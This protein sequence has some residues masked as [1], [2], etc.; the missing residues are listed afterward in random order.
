MLVTPEAIQA[1]RDFYTTVGLTRRASTRHKQWAY[2]IKHA[3]E[4]WHYRN[5]GQ[6]LYVHQD[7]ASEAARQM[8]ADVY[9][10]SHGHTHLAV[11]TRWPASATLRA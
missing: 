7:A 9:R 6:H 4:R 2:A 8:G 3:V 5:T 10:D 11:S 1:C